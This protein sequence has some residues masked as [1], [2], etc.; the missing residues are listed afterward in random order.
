MWS[1]AFKNGRWPLSSTQL[2]LSKIFHFFLFWHDVLKWLQIGAFN[3]LRRIRKCGTPMLSN[4]GKWR[5]KCGAKASGS[6]SISRLLDRLFMSLLWGF[7]LCRRITQRPT[8]ASSANA[9]QRR[10]WKWRDMELWRK[11]RMRGQ[12]PH[13]RT[14]GWASLTSEGGR[15]VCDCVSGQRKRRSACCVLSLCSMSQNKLFWPAAVQTL[16]SKAFLFQPKKKKKHKHIKM[17]GFFF[18]KNNG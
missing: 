2:Q 15:G 17:A 7:A 12:K 4:G 16:K 14:S 18:Q 9:E 13:L 1:K 6:S 3:L 5:S 10:R 11:R 8:G